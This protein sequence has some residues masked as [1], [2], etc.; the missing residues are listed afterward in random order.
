MFGSNFKGR[1]FTSLKKYHRISLV[2][3]VAT[4][5]LMY[6]LSKPRIYQKPATT[7]VSYLYLNKKLKDDF[8][9]FQSLNV[10]L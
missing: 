6:Q 10:V 4:I 3:E 1:L 5:S 9:T 8:E 2:I 7:N